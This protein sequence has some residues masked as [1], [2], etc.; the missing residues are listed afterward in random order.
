LNV[1]PLNIVANTVSPQ[2]GN[3][4]TTSNISNI[5][6][7]GQEVPSGNING[8]NTNFTLAHGTV[9]PLTLLITINDQPLVDNINFTVSGI[10]KQTITF[11]TAPPNK[12]KIFAYYAYGT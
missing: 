8:I 3:P 4:W 11:T 6:F 5:S 1:G 10:S 7:S 9:D 2:T 12:S